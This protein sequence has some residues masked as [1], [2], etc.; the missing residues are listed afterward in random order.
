MVW[1]CASSNK[2]SF[3]RIFS[4][5]DHV[6]LNIGGAAEALTVLKDNQE[7][8]IMKLI[9]KDRKG[10]VKMALQHGAT[11]VPCIA[12]NENLVYY[13]VETGMLKRIQLFLQKRMKF[14]IPL[15]AGHAIL[16]PTMPR[17]QSLC[18]YVGGGLDCPK[19]ANPTQDDIDKK[20]AEYCR[21]LEQLF[22]DYKTHAGHPDWR[23]EIIEDPGKGH[24]GLG[25]KS[26]R[27]V[28]NKSK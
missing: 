22:D 1:G 3:D 20:H 6:C 23:L 10:F 13:V 21:K 12:F 5:G 19:V 4:R 25:R 14:S 17:R 18:M 15:F 24:K 26:L 9:L 7:K 2:K 16:V 28:E 8:G 11:I 27:I